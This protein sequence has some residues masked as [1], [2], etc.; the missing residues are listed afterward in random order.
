M[1][2]KYVLVFYTL[3]FQVINLNFIVTK[4]VFKSVFKNINM[5]YFYFQMTK[6][7]GCR[8]LLDYFGTTRPPTHVTE[9]N[10]T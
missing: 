6:A 1:K 4:Y 8:P 10:P 3:Y 9:F 5:C 7:A 2:L